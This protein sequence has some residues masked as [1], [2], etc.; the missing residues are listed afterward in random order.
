MI[1][2]MSHIMYQPSRYFIMGRMGVVNIGE[3]RETVWLLG[4]AAA[5]LA[6]TRNGA[7][8]IVDYLLCG[9]DVLLYVRSPP[10]YT[11]IYLYAF[12]DR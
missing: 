3:L 2:F 6:R 7:T 12:S 9:F 8:G 1:S 4:T 11:I 5:S 10:L